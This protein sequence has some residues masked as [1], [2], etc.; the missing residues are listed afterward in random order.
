MDRPDTERTATCGTFHVAGVVI[1]VLPSA[2]EKVS[3]EL[4]TI[5]GARVHGA[6]AAGKLV[7][8]L[9]GESTGA[10]VAGLESMRQLPGV[11]DAALVYQHGED[12]A[13]GGLGQ[14]QGGS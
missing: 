4:K 13:E 2:L 7:V 1:H 5:R 10:I 8:T 12:D 9:E 3:G 6:S 14:A 11:I